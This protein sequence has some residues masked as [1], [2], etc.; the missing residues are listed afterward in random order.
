LFQLAAGGFID[1]LVAGPLSMMDGLFNT[2]QGFAAS[3]QQQ[4]QGLS[5]LVNANLTSQIDFQLSQFNSSQNNACTNNL[6][7]E[8]YAIGNKSRK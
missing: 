8:F 1:T 6:T 3:V 2:A 4:F 5:D 7:E